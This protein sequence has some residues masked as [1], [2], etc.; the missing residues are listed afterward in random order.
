MELPRFVYPLLRHL[1]IPPRLHW[2]LARRLNTRFL[3]G[4]A[5]IITDD[6]HRLLL[7]KHT[8]RRSH[9]WGMPGGWMDQGESPLEALEREVYEESRLRIEAQRLLLMGITA[10]RP[11]FEFVVAA[12]VVSGEFTPSREVSAMAW[13]ARDELPPLALFHL[14]ILTLLDNL[15]ADAVSFYEAPWIITH[16][17]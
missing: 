12:K 6:Q 5:G 10:D 9:P 1:R 8:Y 13:Y 14:H 4:V 17:R 16:P 15:P 3:A 11:K 7:F 2:Q